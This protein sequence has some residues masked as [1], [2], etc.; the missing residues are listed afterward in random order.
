[1]KN[2]PEWVDPL[3]CIIYVICFTVLP[4]LANWLS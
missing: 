3:I 4:L 2:I 1:M